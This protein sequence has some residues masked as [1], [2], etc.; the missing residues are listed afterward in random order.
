MPYFSLPD[1]FWITEW[2]EVAEAG[3]AARSR[4]CGKAPAAA[5][6]N[7]E[8]SLA[9]RPSARAVAG[10]VPEAPVGNIRST[11]RLVGTAKT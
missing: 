10:P 11:V 4:R 5:A 1:D 6:G 9:G 7:A 2:Q 8:G 3:A